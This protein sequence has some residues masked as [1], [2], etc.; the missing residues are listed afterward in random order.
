[1]LPAAAG[2]MCPALANSLVVQFK[3]SKD[4]EE[5]SAHRTKKLFISLQDT[6]IYTIVD[7]C[8]V[9]YFRSDAIHN[10]TQ[11]IPIWATRKVTVENLF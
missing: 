9:E 7:F 1:M 8:Q 6:S 3:D 4:P 2:G 10:Y 11:G 5:W